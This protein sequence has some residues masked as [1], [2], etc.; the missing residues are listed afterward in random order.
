[1]KPALPL[2]LVTL[3][4]VASWPAR[5]AD[6][7]AP[8]AFH[9]QRHD[10]LHEVETLVV[11]R[12]KDM[13]SHGRV[14]DRQ[15]TRTALSWRR[16]KGGWAITGR[17]L[18]ASFTRN[19]QAIPDPMLEATRHLTLVYHVGLDGGL[20]RIDGLGG[21]RDT[22]A[23]HFPPEVVAALAPLL[24]P[25]AI[26]AREAA[27][28]NGRYRYFDGATLQVGETIEDESPFV[29]PNGDTLTFRSVTRVAG[30]EPCAPE[31]CV[32]IRID[33]DS[34]ARALERLTT[35][36][37]STIVR[38]FGAD[39][40]APSASGARVSGSVSR[41][42]H[43]GTL[44]VRSEKATRVMRMTVRVPGYDPVAAVVTE[45]RERSYAPK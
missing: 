34:D 1:M 2:A 29:L 15:E 9:F 20:E 32:R 14:I 17:L 31:T 23:S 36:T 25:E 7:E 35:E 44:H 21:V 8:V 41:L 12:E 24:S 30:R 33:Y 16:E 5:A 45:T 26:L 28:W 13:G 42:L 6:S 19:G 37:A 4:G 3:L 39:S 27:E 38:A 11:T 43:P 18:S 10:G 40:L 22:L